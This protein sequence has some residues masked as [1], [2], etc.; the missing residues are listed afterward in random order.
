M[1]S[2]SVSSALN[3]ILMVNYISLFF[4]LK[5]DYFKK[6]ILNK[7]DMS[8]KKNICEIIKTKLFL[9]QEIREYLPNY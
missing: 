9:K 6:W 7:G 8:T 2:P 4:F 1:H 5:T 3:Q